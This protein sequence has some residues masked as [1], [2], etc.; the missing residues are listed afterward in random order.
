MERRK[1]LMLETKTFENFIDDYSGLPNIPGIIEQNGYLLALPAPMEI[2][3]IDGLYKVEATE[4]LE[5]SESVF[6][7]VTD[8]EDYEYALHQFLKSDRFVIPDTIKVLVLYFDNELGVY[9]TLGLRVN[10]EK[11]E[12]KDG[13]LCPHQNHQHVKQFGC[14][15][16]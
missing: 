5:S 10:L 11:L 9:T 3:G 15:L 6:H 4:Q 12:Y 14:F 16:S 1:R 7:I 2:N 13:C 8:N